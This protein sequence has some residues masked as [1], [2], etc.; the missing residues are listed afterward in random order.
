MH[1]SLLQCIL[2]KSDEF[3]N[4]YSLLYI[5]LKSWLCCCSLARLA[6]QQLHSSPSVPLL[7]IESGVTN[8]TYPRQSVSR[9]QPCLCPRT[10]SSRHLFFL[11]WP[12]SCLDLPILRFPSGAHL[13]ATCRRN[14]LS[15]RSTCTM[16]VHLLPLTCSL[17]FSM[18]ALLRPSSRLHRPKDLDKPTHS[19]AELES[20]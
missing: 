4:S 7:S 6:P 9:Q 20:I 14:L 10:V 16:H 15:I 2:V 19:L 8:F 11:S 5:I 13:S 12:A 3:K 17:I 18:L 1:S